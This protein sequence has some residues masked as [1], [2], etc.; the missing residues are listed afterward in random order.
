M[1]HLLALIK[2]PQ[3]SEKFIEYAAGFARELKTDIH[4][5]YVVN[6]MMHPLGTPNLSG[7]AYAQLQRTMEQKVESAR[8]S[9][10]KMSKEIMQRIA[11]DVQFEVSARLGSEITLINEM[12]ESGKVQ[13][14]MIDGRD[15][16]SFWKKESLVK[17]LIR[18]ISCPVWI[19]PEKMDF[20]PFKN[21]VYATDYNEEDI[22]TLKNLIDL[23][24]WFS[25]KITA[26]HISDRSDFELRIKNAGFQ[27]MLE[28]NTNYSQISAKAVIEKNGADMA[29]MINE[30]ASG[31]SADLIVVL[32]ENRRFLER[33]FKSSSTDKLVEETSRP[34]LALQENNEQ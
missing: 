30:Y 1:R 18:Q 21:I 6:H 32:K 16:D 3:L 10:S 8:D 23:T 17:D 7:V 9:I 4:F 14:V 29:G 33:I 11:N 19:I 28:S 20:T 2:D 27:K 12:V 24:H 5:L 22:P 13:M 26:L 25:P 31:V 15:M 34:L